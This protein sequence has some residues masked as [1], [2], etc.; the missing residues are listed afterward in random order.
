MGDPTGAG[1]YVLR[2]LKQDGT[3][4]VVE[5]AAGDQRED[6]INPVS[7]LFYAVEVA[8]KTGTVKWFNA[9]KGYGFLKPDDGGF[10]VYVHITAVERAGMTI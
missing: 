9:R 6:N 3:W 8:M 4:M 2:A 10:N 7:R 5:A 1:R